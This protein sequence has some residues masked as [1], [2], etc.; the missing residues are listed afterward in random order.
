M[1]INTILEPGEVMLF[2]GQTWEQLTK[3]ERIASIEWCLEHCFDR[4]TVHDRFI[5]AWL[6]TYGSEVGPRAWKRLLKQLRTK[7]KTEHG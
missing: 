7:L 4:H 1:S 6:L 2:Q 5:K 3:S